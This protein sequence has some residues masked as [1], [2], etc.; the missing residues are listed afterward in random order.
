M[1]N[2]SQE[3]GA[4]L[5]DEAHLLKILAAQNEHFTCVKMSPNYTPIRVCITVYDWEYD[6]I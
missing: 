1:L 5:R 3:E 6:M 4:K 2:L